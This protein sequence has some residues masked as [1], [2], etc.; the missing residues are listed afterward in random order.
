MSRW[1]RESFFR[2]IS[3]NDDF[4]RSVIKGDVFWV[5]PSDLARGLVSY[6]ARNGVGRGRV[7]TP[8]F[9]K[10]A[11]IKIV[12]LSV[13]RP[14]LSPQHTAL[15]WDLRGSSPAGPWSSPASG[16]SVSRRPREGHQA[17]WPGLRG[18]GSPQW[19]PVPEGSHCDLEDRPL[20]PGEAC[21]RGPA[22]S[23]RS[24][25]PSVQ[26]GPS[27]GPAATCLSHA[28]GPRAAL[29]TDVHPADAAREAS[30]QSAGASWRGDPSSRTRRPGLRRDSEALTSPCGPRAAGWLRR[31]RP[32]WPVKAAVPR[33]AP[34]GRVGSPAAALQV[35]PRHPGVTV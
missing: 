14:G 23:G 17:A 15:S 5:F 6:A 27:P 7:S 19:P 2:F 35:P 33:A 21:L 25:T 16:P 22:G 11:V 26:E 32:T 10:E 31:C 24:H 3:R 4:K 1:R 29:G 9:Y 18:P 8:L 13:F 12:R 28:L 30:S 20:L 34:L